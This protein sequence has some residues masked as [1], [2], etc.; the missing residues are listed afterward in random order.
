MLTRHLRLGRFQW[1][2]ARADEGRN[3]GA[4]P[5]RTVG[6]LVA[7]GVRGYRDSSFRGVSVAVEV[8]LELQQPD[9]QPPA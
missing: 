2:L 8:S 3:D 1:L 7:I 6:G 9:S 5:S 4:V